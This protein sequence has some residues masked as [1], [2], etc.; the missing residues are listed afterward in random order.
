MPYI[1][2]KC[3][4]WQVK[5]YSDRKE[6]Y[7][8]FCVQSD[9]E[10]FA[11]RIATQ[12]EQQQRK[13]RKAKYDAIHTVERKLKRK[14]NLAKHGNKHEC[15]SEAI[16]LM[17]PILTKAN[18]EVKRVRDGAKADLCV[19]KKGEELLYGVQIKSCSKRNK[20][21][22]AQF[23]HVLGYDMPV[24]CVCNDSGEMWIFRGEEFTKDKFGIGRTSK[25][26]IHKVTKHTLANTL[27]TMLSHYTPHKQCYWDTYGLAIDQLKEH[28]IS[29]QADAIREIDGKLFHIRR[30]TAI[31]RV[32]NTVSDCELK[33][34]TDVF[35]PAQEKIVCT[36]RNETG[37]YVPMR[38]KGG[39]IHGKQTRQPYMVGDNRY[40][41]AYITHLDGEFKTAKTREEATRLKLV[42]LF[43]FPESILIEKG[44]LSTSTQIGKTD[45]LVYL[46]DQYVTTLN[47]RAQSRKSKY[48]LT[49]QYFHYI[50]QQ[51]HVKH[52]YV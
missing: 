45:V 44:V 4:R 42:G 30:S 1:R 46:P 12:Y 22:K 38:K 6:K 7:K 40:Y 15:E 13:K 5:Y 48:D 36:L 50:N 21:G 24:I 2:K 10:Q 27:H 51:H 33:F 52:I 37:F 32:E 20:K 17:Y 14:K 35:L 8:S 41:I 31:D 16:R 34:E 19:R 39:M 25:Y 9:A 47:W 11:A 29:L 43:L 18:Y 26:D 28:I 3:N 23:A 49:K